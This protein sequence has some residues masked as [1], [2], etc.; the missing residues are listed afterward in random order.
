MSE[1]TKCV[2]IITSGIVTAVMMV[3]TP[4]V[5]PMAILVFGVITFIV[6]RN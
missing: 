4:D 5:S 1:I 3:V 2:T 6:A